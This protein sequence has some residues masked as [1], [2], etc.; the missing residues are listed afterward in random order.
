MLRIVT[1]LSAM[2]ALAGAFALYAL[3]YDTRRLEAYVAAQERELE[4]AE[5][6][7]AVLKAERAHLAAPERLEKLA[8][9]LGL[10]PPQ[11]GQFVHIDE[12]QVRGARS[13]SERRP[14]RAS[15]G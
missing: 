9:S 14:A 11:R 13:D 7:V 3:K 5:A 15:G 12:L 2:L 1:L 6:D 8:R 4:R 10:V